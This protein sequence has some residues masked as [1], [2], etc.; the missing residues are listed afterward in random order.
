[1]VRSSMI[2]V[3]SVHKEKHSFGRLRVLAGSV[4]T[5]STRSVVKVGG[6][7][8]PEGVITES[9]DLEVLSSSTHKNVACSVLSG[10]GGIGGS[11]FRVGEGKVESMSRIGG[12]AFAI[13]SLVSKDGQCGGGLMASGDMSLDGWVGAGGGKVKDGGVDL[14]VGGDEVRGLLKQH[15]LTLILAVLFKLVLFSL[16]IVRENHENESTRACFIHKACWQAFPGE[17][18]SASV[19][20][21]AKAVCFF[22]NHDVRQQPTKVGFSTFEK[23]IR[24]FSEERSNKNSI[25]VLFLRSTTPFDCGVRGAEKLCVMPLASQKA[26]NYTSLSNS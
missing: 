24:S 5:T 11:K 20:E 10:N 2:L 12:G 21:I 25:K 22:E 17:T 13:R 23:L 3:R 7:L 15:G 6:S 18:Y 9:V 26:P 14:G 8:G 4:P 19:I 1:M 16:G